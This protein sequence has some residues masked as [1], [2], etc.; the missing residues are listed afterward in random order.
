MLPIANVGVGH[1]SD[2]AALES[3]EAAFD[4]SFGLRSWSDE[5]SD[6]QSPQG[7]LEL[8]LGV[9]VVTA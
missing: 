4:F 1:K 3:A 8:A 6:A 7:A 5:V 9:G 2:E